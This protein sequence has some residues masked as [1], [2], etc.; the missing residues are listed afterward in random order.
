MADK[1]GVK[2]VPRSEFTEEYGGRPVKDDDSD[3]SL[4][5]GGLDEEER[6]E[7]DWTKVERSSKITKKLTLTMCV[8]ASNMLVSQLSRQIQTH[9]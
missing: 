9:Q 5:C 6:D 8:L 7:G 4:R 1:M 2:Y 3:S